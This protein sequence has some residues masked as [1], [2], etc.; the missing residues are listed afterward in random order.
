MNRRSFSLS[1]ASW[2]LVACA[3]CGTSGTTPSSS[4]SAGFSSGQ[5]SGASAPSGAATTGSVVNPSSGASSASGGGTGAASSGATSGD[6]SAEAGAVS[7]GSASGASSGAAT[8]GGP[9]GAATGATSGATASGSSGTGSSGVLLTNDGGVYAGQP[10]MGTPQQIPGFIKMANYDTGGAGV[11]WC[12]GYPDNCANRVN[13]GDWRGYNGVYRPVAPGDKACGGAGCTDNVGICHMNGGEPDNY[14]SSGPSWIAG[15][16]GPTLTGPMVKLGTNVMPQDVYPCY[17][18]SPTSGTPS[19]DPLWIKF[20]VQVTEPG[21]FSI[22][23]FAGVFPGTTFSFDFG[24]GITSGIVPIPASPTAGCNCPETFH[25][26]Q[27]YQNLGS[28]TV[29]AAGLYVLT[30]TLLTHELNPD[31]FTF[32]KM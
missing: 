1:R 7:S 32:T 22:G 3:A 19:P 11:A 10:F 21:T 27:M 14:A 24:G 12:H 29:P 31:Y 18:I 15:A 30:F 16:D 23:G 26:W 9:S 8:G 25:S 28:V 6:S 2:V 5:S 17:L 20:T 4:T 13:T